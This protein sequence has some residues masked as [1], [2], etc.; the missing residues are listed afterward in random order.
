MPPRHNTFD[1]SDEQF[2]R[3]LKLRRDRAAITQ[4]LDRILGS[5]RE[6]DRPSWGPCLRCGYT[7][8]GLWKN[9]KPRH[10]A[11]CHAPNWDKPKQSER[12]Q[13]PSPTREMWPKRSLSGLTPPPLIEVPEISSWPPQPE[14]SAKPNEEFPP[15]VPT[16]LPDPPPDEP[17]QPET[18]EAQVIPSL[19]EQYAKLVE[20]APE[21][22]FTLEEMQSRCPHPPYK[23][24]DG[25][26]I[27][28]GISLD[29]ISIPEEP[30]GNLDR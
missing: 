17:N 3:V 8:K 28:C 13:R 26:C 2:H 25:V 9:Q 10:C 30:D 14:R 11:K 6:V 29:K 27:G 15:G 21:P 7:W 18:E 12:V 5:V 4:E 19:L 16:P 1:L 23:H 22:E 24:I 20:R